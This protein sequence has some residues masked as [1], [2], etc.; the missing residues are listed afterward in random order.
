MPRAERDGASAGNRV[1]SAGGQ[2]PLA[3]AGGV[4]SAAEA[5][6]MST[7]GTH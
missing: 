6:R 7:E 1:R 3:A 5:N 4:A 2:V